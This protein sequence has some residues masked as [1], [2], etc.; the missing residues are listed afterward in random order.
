[1][2]KLFSVQLGN[3]CLNRGMFHWGG[4][5]MAD[6]EDLPLLSNEPAENEIPDLPTDPETYREV[7]RLWADE[8]MH[9]GPIGK[10]L[11][12]SSRNVRT[13]L[14]RA[15]RWLM[16]EN[17]RLSARA[18]Q[19]VEKTELERCLLSTFDH[20][21]DVYVVPGGQ[22]KSQHEYDALLSRWTSMAAAYFDRLASE[23]AIRGRDLRV[24][25]SGGE[26]ILEF[27]NSLPAR[28][29]ANV[30]FYASALIGRTHLKNTSHVDAIANV[31]V[32]WA[33]SGRWPDR[34]IYA[35]V[36]PYDL[37]VRCNSYVARRQNVL[38]EIRFLSE[39][40]PIK[41]YL[42]TDLKDIDIAIAGLGTVAPPKHHSL[43]GVRFT[44]VDLLRDTANI[45]REDLERDGAVGEI[46]YCFFD[47]DGNGN[48]KK[49]R[50]YLTAGD[51]DEKLRGV[52]FFRDMVK[53]R[54]DVIVM[55]GAFKES[56][57][58]AALKGKLFNVWFTNEAAAREVLS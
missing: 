25:M 10:E 52:Q 48:N 27:V 4:R 15:T 50:F 5:A 44:A 8:M 23:A 41:Q 24:C 13:L 1:M 20:L 29:R 16:E 42:Q 31:T 28:D 38:D 30:F 33:R 3:Y 21:K 43:R 9:F 40:P 17:V 49:W 37:S 45:D 54:K 36:S 58:K 51:H 7:L 2:Q 14:T 6:E 11:R 32:A 53:G 34:C 26:T 22:I 39:L 56:A 35:T 12:V 18:P 19:I 57:L 46:G 47:R 55:A